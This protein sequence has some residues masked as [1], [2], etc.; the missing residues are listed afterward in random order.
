[1]SCLD[2]P[3]ALANIHGY[4]SSYAKL[5]LL[6]L[7]LHDVSIQSTVSLLWVCIACYVAV[8]TYVIYL[9][10][11]TYANYLF[12]KSLNWRI[13][14]IH[15]INFSGPT[16]LIQ[17]AI[18]FFKPFVTAVIMDRVLIHD[19]L[20]EVYKYVPR[21]CFPSDYGGEELSFTELAGKNL[22]NFIFG[23]NWK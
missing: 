17:R 1:M 21:E 9:R 5:V 11:T 7:A 6:E 2:T 18:N 14:G 19:S 8:C 16:N 15:V 3:R 20:E 23:R 13:Y 22:T 12:Q 4:T 10:N